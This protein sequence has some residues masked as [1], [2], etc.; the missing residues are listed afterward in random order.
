MRCAGTKKSTN[1]WHVCA[2]AYVCGTLLTVTTY[3]QVA[4]LEPLVLPMDSDRA[5]RLLLSAMSEEPK[6]IVLAL[7]PPAGIVTTGTIVTGMDMELSTL[8][9]ESS[10]S[11]LVHTGAFIRSKTEENSEIYLHTSVLASGSNA[12]EIRFLNSSGRAEGMLMSRL[13]TMPEYISRFPHTR[14]IGI[15]S[16]NLWDTL[17]WLS[18]QGRIQ[19]RLLN[20]NYSRA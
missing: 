13:K 7:D 11:A 18:N 5:L 8:Q 2:L 17:D 1:G 3:A 16:E 14:T 4:R 19:L 10:S 9:Q 12:T 15:P 20:R 6:A